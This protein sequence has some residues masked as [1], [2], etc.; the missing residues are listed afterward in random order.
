MGA[1]L[2]A[3]RRPAFFLL[4]VLRP[5]ASVRLEGAG[6]S[7]NPSPACPASRLAAARDGLTN[8]LRLASLPARS[9]TL[10]RTSWSL[11]VSG[12]HILRPV[13]VGDTETGVHSRL[14]VGLTS[15]RNDARS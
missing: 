6:G 14:V 12:S 4:G 13:R 8:T 11:L 2:S 10:S 3:T 1:L 7:D 9:R 5:P 15:I